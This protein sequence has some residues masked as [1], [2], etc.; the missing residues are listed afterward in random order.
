MSLD[1]TVATCA[2]SSSYLFNRIIRGVMDLLYSNLD[3]AR[4]IHWKSIAVSSSKCLM[5]CLYCGLRV[6]DQVRE[7]RCCDLVDFLTFW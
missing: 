6:L 5:A 7:G 3:V 2:L 4:D 1:P